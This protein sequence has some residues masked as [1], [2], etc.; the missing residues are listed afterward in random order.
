MKTTNTIAV[1]A[2]ALLAVSSPALAQSGGS[3]PPSAG[4]EDVMPAQ[5]AAAPADDEIIVTARKRSEGLQAVPIAVSAVTASSLEQR[6]IVRLDQ[7]SAVVP[8]ATFKTAA[9]IPTEVQPFIRSIGD[10]SSE[11]SQDLSNAISIDGVY[12][13]NIAGSNVDTF[14]VE[15]IEVLRGPQGVLQG[16]NSTGGAVNIRTKRPSGE[17]H[18]RAM[19]SYERFDA[20]QLKGYVE[21]PLAQDVLAVK[22]SAFRT[23]GG[24]YSRNVITGERDT[25]GIRAAGGRIGL[26][27]TPSSDFTA[28]LTA[29]YS[30]DSSP[31][32]AV[33]AA[34][35]SGSIA[36]PY[37]GAYAQ[38]QPRVCALFQ[39]CSTYAPYTNAFSLTGPNHS[40]NRGLALNLDWDIGGITLS[41]VT[42]YRAV[43]QMTNIDLDATPSMIFN[44]QPRNVR[45]RAFSQETRLASNGDGP[46]SWL[47]GGYYLRSRIDLER[48]SVLGGPLFGQPVGVTSTGTQFRSPDTDSYA[49]FGQLS[50][51]ITDQWDISVGGR[52]S[53]DK[54]SLVSTPT[55]TSGTGVFKRD[56]NAF[57]MEATTRYRFTPDTLVYLRFAQGYRSGGFNGAATTLAGINSFEP[58]KNDAY[59]IGLKSSWLDRRLKLNLTGFYYDYRDLQLIAIDQA[60]GIGLIQ[61]V[62]NAKGLR[63]S[64]IEFETSFSVTDNFTLTGNLSYLHTKYRS[65]I[66]NL[67]FGNIDLADAKRQYAPK[68][69]GMVQAQYSIPIGDNKLVLNGS[70]NYRSLTQ[71]NDVPTDVAMQKAYALV[72]AEIAWHL[73]DDRV[74]LSLFGQNLTDKYYK[75]YGDANGGLFNLV[76]DGRPRTYGVRATVKF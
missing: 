60:P 45:I 57:T 68:I 38:P 9:S 18:A 37:N 39:E 30:K 52:Q 66:L 75:A 55:A 49:L 56:F 72:D 71:L 32:P 42:G 62:I 10:R 14:D 46:F 16:R 70:L 2:I 7:M 64:G 27:F 29:D 31:P 65:Q 36:A 63:A 59:E 47:V 23:T 1:S 48:T 15:Q 3:A 4:A 26:L 54:K 6:N 12:L 19:V 20:L 33:R 53:W 28:Y 67:G 69:T 13:V 58:E 25:G 41:S 11:P 73:P 74:T 44:L 22:L 40:K 50:Y 17:L 61:R 43:N 5:E 34:N 21:A 35:H 24:N 76:I 51:Q 8:N